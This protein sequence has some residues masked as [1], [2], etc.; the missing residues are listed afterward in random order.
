MPIERE[1]RFKTVGTKDTVSQV[2]YNNIYFDSKPVATPFFSFYKPKFYTYGGTLNYYSQDPYAIFTNLVRPP[3][4]FVFSSHTESLSGDSYFLHEIYRLDYDTYKL[5]S[6][7]QLDDKQNVVNNESLNLTRPISTSSPTSP[8]A[9]LGASNRQFI[10][11][12]TLKFG[13]NPIP[14]PEKFFG[15]ALTTK[16]FAT[17]Q[18]FL[19][20][21]LLIITASTS[22]ITGNIYD[23]FLEQSIKKFGNYKSE[24][25]LDKSQYIINSK[26]VFNVNVNKN[27]SDFFSLLD[28]GGSRPFQSSWNDVVT[29]TATNS[30]PHTINDGPFSGMIVSGNYFTYFVVPDK[31]K[32]EYPIMSGQLTTFTPEFRWS[33]GDNADSFVVQ[34]NYN[35]GDTGFTGTVYNYPVEK[36]IEN[37]HIVRST[38]KDSTTELATDKTIYTFQVAMKSNKSFL[39]R[40]GN[41]KELIDIFD[42][43]RNVVTFSD[44]FMAI[45]QPEPIKTYVYIESDSKQV[46]EIA[47]YSH[48]PS[49]DYESE[50]AEFS[51]SGHVSGSTVTGATMQLLC[52]NSSTISTTTDLTG[53]YSFSGLET[54][55]YTLTT[56]YRGY[57][58]DVRTFTLNSNTALNFKLHLLWG[59]SVDTW[60]KMAGESYY[61]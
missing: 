17:I 29:I 37:S 40:V 56:N 51:L 7:N 14:V 46:V 57:Q 13:N 52:P 23:L 16:D 33:N 47:G 9:N 44:Y 1:I 35:T 38:S 31:P 60:G 10:N 19:S 42:V 15:S 4:R 6:D 3:I 8:T 48:P 45:S 12:E 22:A 26:I 43:R 54:G 53:L 59:D 30:I 39:Y 61:T 36:K 24:L 20:V 11:S 34:I 49:L 2:F 55:S 32:L 21:P 18:N 27:Y 25:F 41:S 5:F 28:T 50:V 58:Q